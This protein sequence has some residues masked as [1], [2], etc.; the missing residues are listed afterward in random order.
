MKKSIYKFR[1]LF[2]L[3]MLA[4]AII[5]SS[6]NKDDDEDMQPQTEPQA[7]NIFQTASADTQFS[8]LV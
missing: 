2:V 8:I 6:C 3:P 7:K 1:K 5:L 4:G